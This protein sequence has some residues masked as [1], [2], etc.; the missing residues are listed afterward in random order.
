[1]ASNEIQSRARLSKIVRRKLT[2]CATHDPYALE[3]IAQLHLSADAPAPYPSV[4]QSNSEFVRFTYKTRGLRSRHQA[5]TLSADLRAASVFKLNRHVEQRASL[6][7]DAGASC[8]CAVFTAKTD[9]THTETEA[10][11]SL[12]CSSSPADTL[13]SVPSRITR[14]KAR[15]FQHNNQLC[16]RTFAVNSPVRIAPPTSSE[17]QSLSAGDAP[18][19]RHAGAHLPFRTVLAHTSSADGQR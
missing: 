6:R 8:R 15:M 3:R 7:G 11:F 2:Y 17:R 1:M 12:A 18:P 16:F 14:H 10:L 4:Q 5:S 19:I 13:D 9:I